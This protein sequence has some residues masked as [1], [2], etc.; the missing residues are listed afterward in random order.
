MDISNEN[1]DDGYM[2]YA[3]GDTGGTYEDC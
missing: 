2:C 3:D 1:K